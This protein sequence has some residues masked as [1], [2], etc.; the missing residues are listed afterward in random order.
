[1]ASS[2]LPEITVVLST[3]D[4][5]GVFEEAI[6]SWTQRQRVAAERFELVVSGRADAEQQEILARCLRPGDRHV[7]TAER[8]SGTQW[9]L[10]ALE[11]RAPYLLFTEAHCSAAPGCLAE[12]LSQFAETGAD[13]LALSTPGTTGSALEW[14]DERFCQGEFTARPLAARAIS[15]RAFAIRKRTYEALGAIEPKLGAFGD[16]H[17]AH[18]VAAS[19]VHVVDAPRAGVLHHNV[20]TVQQPVYCVGDYVTGEV[21]WRSRVPEAEA[22]DSFGVRPIL[23]LQGNRDPVHLA[24]ARTALRRAARDALLGSNGSRSVRGALRALK[25][26]R[27][28]TRVEATRA[29]E[30]RD[31]IDRRVDDLRGR[32]ADVQKDD[33]GLEIYLA[34]WR[35]LAEQK[36]HALVDAGAARLHVPEGSTDALGSDRVFGLSLPLRQ[37][38]RWVRMLRGVGGVRLPAAPRDAGLVIELEPGTASGP[39]LLLWNGT[40]VGH[41]AA[42]ER[43]VELSEAALPSVGRPAD[44]EDILAL[45]DVEHPEPKWSREP[46]A[47]RD[48]GVIAIERV[49]PDARIRHTVSPERTSGNLLPASEASAAP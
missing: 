30:D 2:S 28:L 12:V 21:T 9:A 5:R 46:R 18:R 24:A 22:W 11:A 1:M 47:G 31:A 27:R 48:V 13:V 35:M 19:D 15:P 37:E 4:P 23:A 34:Y 36:E 10:G 40:V 49:T 8:D 14:L 17:L 7:A 16:F 3:I 41:I 25:G 20:P 38:Q 39:V 32:L 6:T 29:T 45:V 42:G 44:G 43:R 26:L 33:E